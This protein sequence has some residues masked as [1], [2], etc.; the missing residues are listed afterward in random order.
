MV[1]AVLAVLVVL[2]ALFPDR[3]L[4]P[5]G[6]APV[7]AAEAADPV[8]SADADGA[9]PVVELLAVDDVLET[10][11]GESGPGDEAAA[12]LPKSPIAS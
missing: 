1:L 6:A 2:A 8:L 3:L 11:A 4:V 7:P 12:G 5:D 9:A 10:D